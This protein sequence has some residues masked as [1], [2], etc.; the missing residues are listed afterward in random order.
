MT[1]ISLLEPVISLASHKERILI[2]GWYLHTARSKTHFMP[3]EVREF[4]ELLSL[5]QP[6]GFGGYFQQLVSD[7]ALLKDGSGYRLESSQRKRLQVK[8]GETEATVQITALLASL[9]QK[10]PDLEER[11]YLNEA[12]ICYRHGAF[13]A[14]VVMTWNLAYHHLCCFV[15]ARKLDEFNASV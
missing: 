1:T 7:R 15:L 10:I 12:L 13:R 14:T 9:P 3:S 5:A 6:S 11:T 8:H 4:Y 2:L